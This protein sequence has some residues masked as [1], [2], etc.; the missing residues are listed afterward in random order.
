MNKSKNDRSRFQQQLDTCAFSAVVLGVKQEK[1]RYTIYNMALSRLQRYKGIYPTHLHSFPGEVL[2]THCT[3][4]L[5]I[6]LFLDY[7]EKDVPFTYLGSCSSRT[8][9][10]SPPMVKYYEKKYL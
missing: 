1:S 6:S 9:I 3:S 8:R 4:S 2:L 10:I 7:S 5:K